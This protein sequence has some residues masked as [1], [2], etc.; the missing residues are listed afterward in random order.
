MVHVGIPILL[1]TR[2]YVGLQHA[3]DELTA[4]VKQAEDA[5]SNEKVS[6]AISLLYRRI[7][8]LF[9]AMGLFEQFF[10]FS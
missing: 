9:F 7:A 2:F 8:A 1:V 3:T 5:A 6:S 10:G 4:P